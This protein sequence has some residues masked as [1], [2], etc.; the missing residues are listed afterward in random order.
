MLLPSADFY[1]QRFG[2]E[3]IFSDAAETHVKHELYILKFTK[4]CW[5]NFC[6]KN[7]L[8]STETWL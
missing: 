6:G 4:K 1:I 7:R 2:G 3:T 5:K 8:L